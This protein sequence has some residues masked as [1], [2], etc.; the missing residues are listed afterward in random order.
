MLLPK[1]SQ[2]HLRVSQLKAGVQDYRLPSPFS[3]NKSGLMLE[4]T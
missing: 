2:I 1:S 3:K 4:A